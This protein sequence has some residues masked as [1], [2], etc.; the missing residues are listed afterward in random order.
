MTD[1]YALLKVLSLNGFSGETKMIVNQ[2]D[3]I[4]TAKTIFHKFR[5]TVKQYLQLKLTLAGIVI[6]DP[7]LVESVKKRQPHLLLYPDSNASKCVKHMAKVLLNQAPDTAVPKSVSSFWQRCFYLLKNPMNLGTNPGGETKKPSEETEADATDTQRKRAKGEFKSDSKGPHPAIRKK[8]RRKTP[9]DG[10]PSA[11][12]LSKSPE[13]DPAIRG[14]AMPAVDGQTTMPFLM[15]Q[16]I[17]QISSISMELQAIRTAMEN[18]DARNGIRHTPSGLENRPAEPINLD[19]EAFCKRRRVREE[20][21]G[22][23]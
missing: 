5:D 9:V 10:D 22:H 18:G 12:A 21:E 8:D 13:T 6:K 20:N 17:D 14:G 23:E 1:A 2:C 4:A 3:N 15:T 16:L 19:F 7:K 11:D